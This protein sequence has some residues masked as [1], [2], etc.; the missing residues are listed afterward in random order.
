M[1][2]SFFAGALGGA[3]VQ[4]VISG[5]DKFSGTFAKANKSIKMLTKVAAI[6]AVGVAS[7]FAVSIKRAAE[8]EA[9]TVAFTTMLG[10]AATA[11]KL[12]NDLANFAKKTPFT[13]QG[14]EKAST[15]LLAVGL[16]AEEI[17]PA[18]NSLGNIAAGTNVPISQLAKAL[19]DVRAKGKLSGEE[20]RQFTNAGVN[21][22]EELSKL[23]GV[24]TAEISKLSEAGKIGFEEVR[25]ALENLSSEGGRFFNLMQKKSKTAIGQ[26]S[27]LQD[28]LELIARDIGKELLPTVNEA[29]TAI[30][31]TITENK[32]E[33]VGFL[34][35]IAKI[36]GVILSASI[37][38]LGNFASIMGL[39]K[40]KGAEFGAELQKLQMAMAN[41]RITAI[42]YHQAAFELAVQYGMVTE[43]TDSLTTST[44]ANTV[45]MIEG[46]EALNERT[47]A[48]ERATGAAKAFNDILTEGGIGDVGIA[49][50][51]KGGK[52]STFNQFDPDT[53]IRTFPSNFGQPILVETRVELDGRQIAS[54]V[55]EANNREVT[56]IST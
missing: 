50:G 16:T 3:S 13:L 21:L 1:V 49:R 40:D 34:G 43:E 6:A 53:G 9:T 33:I 22:R 35:A 20:I 38:E 45:S 12:L 19:G 55:G 56:S 36:G 8:F 51:D 42:Q 18:L 47:K 44:N 46:N 14:I 26:F 32:E 28:E 11:T 30:I 27:N 5:V 2:S 31:S 37:N 15:Q 39:T 7:I 17:L 10:S 29:L 48:L 24:G 54:A 25:Q 23:L 52:L 4:V 41:G